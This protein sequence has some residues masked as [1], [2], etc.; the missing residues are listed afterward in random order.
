M[1]AIVLHSTRYRLEAAN[2]ATDDL[3]HGRIRG[4]VIL[5]PG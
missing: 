4:R 2:N 3:R 1:K 5:S